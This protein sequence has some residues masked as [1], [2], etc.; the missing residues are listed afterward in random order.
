MYYISFDPREKFSITIKRSEKKAS[1]EQTNQAFKGEKTNTS[2]KQTFEECN[3]E[4]EA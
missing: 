4:C 1:V 3:R 2:V